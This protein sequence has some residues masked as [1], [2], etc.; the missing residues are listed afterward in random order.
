MHADP[1][2]LTEFNVTDPQH[3][4]ETPI[5]SIWRVKQA[6]GTFACLKRYKDDDLR[7]EAPGFDLLTAQDG[8]GAV[9]IYRQH[10]AAI[11]MEWLDG[12]SLGDM[13]RNGDDAQATHI[14]GDVA[15]ELHKA[16]VT[17]PHSLDPLPNR[18]KALFAA[19]FTP[20]CPPQVRATVQAARRLATDLLAKQTNIRALHGDLH[21]DNVRG[22]ARGF[23]AF[24]AKGVLGEPTFELANAFRNP[25]GSD[26]LFS[27]PAVILRRAEQWS[28]ALNVTQSYMLSWAAAYSALSLSWTHNSVFGP[29]VAKDMTLIDTFL[30]LRAQGTSA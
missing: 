17:P 30:K 6:D 15:Q 27:D 3:V 16:D 14:L 8:V 1:R 19:T 4:T 21:H 24:D 23:L 7:D 2:L 26:T 25:L 20:D 18:F 29:D 12:P 22:S 5:A 9:R 11:L 10:G 28:A 13:A